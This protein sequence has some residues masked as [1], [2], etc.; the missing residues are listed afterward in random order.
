MVPPMRSVA[1]AAFFSLNFAGVSAILCVL[2][3]FFIRQKQRLGEALDQKHRELEIEQGKS[4]R[5]LLSI[6]PAPIAQRLKDEQTIAD[7][8]P[9]VT[10]MF[11]DIVGFTRMSEEVT[12]RE[13]VAM[14]NDVFS[15][16]D[17]LSER[18]G[19]EKIKTIGDA[20]MVAGGLGGAAGSEAAVAAMALDARA[21]VA[22]HPGV[23]SR[24]LALHIGISTGPV[25]AA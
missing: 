19:L 16:F 7:A 1:G 25:V 12:P 5:L 4:E 13:I 21:Q 15:G 17:A 3:G 23:A 24:R 14:L 6:L 22:R 2:F 18:Y 11:A 8:H 20:Y 10:V 9:E